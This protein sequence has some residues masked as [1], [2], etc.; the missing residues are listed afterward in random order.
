MR[1]AATSVDAYRSLSL[2]DYL[3]PREREVMAV[4]ERE[5]GARYTRQQLADKTGQK[6]NCICGR[7]RSLLD[8]NRL[9]VRGEFYDTETRKWHQTLAV[10]VAG[11]KE[12]WQ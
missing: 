7:V 9:E 2:T 5:P 1:V 8:K 10:P 3:Q 6:L 11:Q 12:L 4:F